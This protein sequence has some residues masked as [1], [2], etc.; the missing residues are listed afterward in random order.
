VLSFDENGFEPQQHS[1]LRS[2]T[3]SGQP[4]SG[5]YRQQTYKAST[6]LSDHS[7]F[8]TVNIN[9]NRSR[10]SNKPTRPSTPSPTNTSTKPNRLSIAEM[11]FERQRF[12]VMLQILHPLCFLLTSVFFVMA[13]FGLVGQ[14]DLRFFYEFVYRTTLTPDWPVFYIYPCVLFYEL[15]TLFWFVLPFP[16]SH[17]RFRLEFANSI[18]FSLVGTWLSETGLLFAFLNDLAWLALVCAFI[19]CMALFIGWY[20]SAALTVKKET[21]DEDERTA[22]LTT[23]MESRL[24]RQSTRKTEARAQPTNTANSSTSSKHSNDN[25]NFSIG[26]DRFNKQGQTIKASAAYKRYYGMTSSDLPPLSDTI[27]DY[28]NSPYDPRGLS[29][30]SQPS[31]SI[32]DYNN[33]GSSQELFRP[34]KRRQPT[35]GSLRDSTYGTFW[36]KSRRRFL[37]SPSTRRLFYYLVQVPIAAHFGVA[38][39]RALLFMQ[40]VAVNAFVLSPN[41]QSGLVYEIC[42]GTALCIFSLLCAIF[43]IWQ[44]DLMLPTIVG[45]GLVAVALRTPMCGKDVNKCDASIELVIKDFA[46]GG[47][48]LQGMALLFVAAVYFWQYFAQLSKEEERALRVV[49]QS[50]QRRRRRRRRQRPSSN[51]L[52]PTHS[53]AN[54]RAASK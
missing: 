5:E 7:S 24:R 8:D 45:T 54:S 23:L 4:F 15:I 36:L 41:E 6:S 30:N 42:F 40:I 49:E 26:S 39:L 13:L 52:S 27:A 21:S 53:A 29:T 22:A 47:A 37:A 44:L 20:Q 38:L 1:S 11:K 32:D 43:A 14:G 28:A 48:I 34:K 12:Y 3:S 46:I 35:S 31:S 19:A 17:H 10:R 25:F 33:E 9:N 50:E 18:S 2:A 16:R 51:T